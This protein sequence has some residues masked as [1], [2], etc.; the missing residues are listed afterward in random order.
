[1]NT[2]S[3]ITAAAIIATASAVVTSTTA[4]AA[5]CFGRAGVCLEQIAKWS[6]PNGQYKGVNVAQVQGRGAPAIAP[7]T[8]R[9][10]TSVVNYERL[11]KPGR[12]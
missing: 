3:L 6:T 7:T 2:K 5:E 4:S 10:D 11:Y 1:M 9:R 8:S 12:A